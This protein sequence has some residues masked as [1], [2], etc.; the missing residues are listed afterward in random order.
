MKKNI[1]ILVI[2]LVAIGAG[3]GIWRYQTNKIH[4]N[5]VNQ[6]KET[7]RYEAKKILKGS[8]FDIPCS[9]IEIKYV[10]GLYLVGFDDDPIRT[11]ESQEQCIDYCLMELT[12]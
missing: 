8:A 7:C 1:I 11:F 6:C 2:V 12:K 3:I 4:Q 5:L 10:W 9:E